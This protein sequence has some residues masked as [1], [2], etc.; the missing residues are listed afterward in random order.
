MSKHPI[1]LMYKFNCYN[2]SIHPIDAIKKAQSQ[3]KKKFDESVDIDVV[4]GI[5]PRKPGQNIRC[6][7]EV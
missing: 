2:Q 1:L 7:A 5:D 3:S 6:Q 4:L